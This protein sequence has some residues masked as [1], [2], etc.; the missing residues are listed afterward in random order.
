MHLGAEVYAITCRAEMNCDALGKK[1]RNASRL[2][3]QMDEKLARLTR[4]IPNADFGTALVKTQTRPACARF[5]FLGNRSAVDQPQR[6]AGQPSLRSRNGLLII[7]ARLRPTR[8]ASR[9]PS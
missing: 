8:G 3:S 4:A 1:S 5:R 9:P 6:T 7:R 2:G